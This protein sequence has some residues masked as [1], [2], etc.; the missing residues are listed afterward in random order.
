V[1]NPAPL[2]LLVSALAI[3]GQPMGPPDRPSTMPIGRRTERSIRLCA[4]RDMPM[5]SVRAADPR[6]A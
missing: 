1:H 3:I 6:A 5:P 4:Q 2:I